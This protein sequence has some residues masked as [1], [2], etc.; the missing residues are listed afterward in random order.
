[1]AFTA[2]RPGSSFLNQMR[3]LSREKWALIRPFWVSE[4]KRRARRMLVGILAM[5]GAEIALAA[6]T[7]YGIKGAVDALFKAGDIVSFA[8]NV[9]VVTGAA[10]AISKVGPYREKTIQSLQLCWR[11]W[12]TKQ[13][14]RAWLGD[15]LHHRIQTNGQPD[16]NPDQR[17]AEDISRFS[18]MTLGLGLGFLRSTLNLVTWAAVLWQ[19]SPLMLGASAVFAFA[20]SGLSHKV[21]EPLHRLNTILQNAEARLRHGLVH[22]KDNAQNIAASG[23]AATQEMAL[24]EKFD[25]VARARLDL[26][27]RQRRLNEVISFNGQSPQIVPLLLA[28]PQALARTMTPGEFLLARQS[29]TEV[30]SSLS[31]FSNGYHMFADWN[32]TADRL[33]AFSRAL[34]EAKRDITGQ[35]PQGPLPDDRA[36]PI[37]APVTPG[38][39]FK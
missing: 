6:G 22:V 30:Y 29:Y 34:E 26:L 10:A 32:A 16:I 36:S 25:D 7:G 31:W 3:F 12:L 38:P 18:D 14:N 28:A 33:T 2:F 39:T 19:A 37:T 15:D 24:N 35:R 5:M 4:E 21:G 8:A 11:G 23:Q 27:E 9:G 20:A 17:I 1:M 13:F